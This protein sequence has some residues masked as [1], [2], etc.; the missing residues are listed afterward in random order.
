M[1][2]QNSSRN[3]LLT[4]S[5][6]AVS[7]PSSNNN[8]SL[9]S[10]NIDAVARPSGSSEENKLSNSVRNSIRKVVK[11]AKKITAAKKLLQH[12]ENF[13]KSGTE[14]DR[15]KY[16]KNLKNLRKQ[17]DD[18]LQEKLKET[19]EHYRIRRSSAAPIKY[20]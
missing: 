17:R 19:A 1:N 18:E 9:K 2:E 8:A 12:K 20:K 11:K 7:P 3:K 10:A 15:K 4:S 13:Q 16:E 6:Y 14:E 5:K